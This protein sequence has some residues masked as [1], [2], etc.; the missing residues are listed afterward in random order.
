MNRSFNT[1]LESK[2]YIVH[3]FTINRTPKVNNYEKFNIK[4]SSGYIDPVT[5]ESSFQEKSK[6]NLSPVH[7]ERQITIN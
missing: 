6:Q 1:N 2:E 7:Q 3:D 4:G 5:F